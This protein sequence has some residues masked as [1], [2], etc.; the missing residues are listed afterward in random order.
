MAALPAVMTVIH[1]SDRTVVHPT[2]TR[3]LGL[4]RGAG[5][6]L[7]LVITELE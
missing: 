7:S 4:I 2:I 6:G 5:R 1:G 3:S